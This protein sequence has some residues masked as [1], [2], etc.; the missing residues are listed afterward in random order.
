MVLVPYA[1][2]SLFHTL[3]YVR[4]EILPTVFPPSSSLH[5][6]VTQRLSPLILAFS[7]NYQAK[8]LRFISYFEVWVILPVLILSIFTG[9]VSFLTPFLFCH[10]LRF[11]FFFSPM[12]RE[13]F[14][15]L[16]LKTDSVFLSPN[17]PPW[18]R[19]FYLKAVEWIITYGDV[20]Q[21]ASRPPQ[22]R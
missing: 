12:T 17:S 5:A 16:K 4:S 10:F 21:R 9:R 11:R 22:P 2:F 3:N 18:L 20:E 1:T 14:G 6:S 8:A 15:D 13:A 7:Q 19:S